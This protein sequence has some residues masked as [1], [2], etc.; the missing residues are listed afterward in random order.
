MGSSGHWS[1]K[2]VPTKRLAMATEL[3]MTDTKKKTKTEPGPQVLSLKAPAVA[4]R[5]IARP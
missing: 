5:L 3:K 2:T 1:L 4:K